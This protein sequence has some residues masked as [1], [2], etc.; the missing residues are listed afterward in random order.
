VS[1]ILCAYKDATSLS[2]NRKGKRRRNRKTIIDTDQLLLRN[3]R[4]HPTMTSKDL[5]RDLLTSGMDIDASAVR[6][7]L[8]AGGKKS[9]C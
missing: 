8:R 4:L 3:S 9:N 6:R 2:L 1:R 5:Q 7:R